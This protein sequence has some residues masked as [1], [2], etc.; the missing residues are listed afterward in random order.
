MKMKYFLKVLFAICLFACKER[1]DSPVDSPSHGYLVVEGIINTGK[2]GSSIT[3]SKIN[4]LKQA[5]IA[6]VKGATVQI[7]DE[8]NERYALPE[9]N[10]GVYSSDL[11]TLDTTRKYRVHIR[12]SEGK[13]YISDFGQGK[14]T[15]PID[16]V[17]WVREGGGLSILVNTH[18]I[19]NTTK[20]YR[21]EYEQTF[22]FHSGFAPKLKY[23]LIPLNPG[24]F[25]TVEYL[26]STKH[27]ADTSK[28]T[29]WQTSKSNSIIL[30]STA[31]LSVDKINMPIAAFPNGAKELSVLYTI[32]VKQFALTR[33]EYEYLDIMRKNTEITGSVFD[34]QPS[35]LKGNIHCIS[36]PDEPVIG[37]I[38]V[39]SLEEKR[40]FIKNS[41]LPD[42]KYNSACFEIPVDNISDSIV[43]P[44]ERGLVPTGPLEIAGN[45]VMVFNVTTKDCIDC[46]LS[47]TRSK[48]DFWP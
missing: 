38:G 35:Q 34:P 48:P 21:W 46:T 33:E 22:E 45:R 25:Y 47:G 44:Y 31:K 9:K 36:N 23:K 41:D 30:G 43:E 11:L 42:W 18:D 14:K 1:Y 2:G 19:R 6:Y 17:N 7:E 13:E 5:N 39:S 40:I 27:E 24:T 28:Y 37:Y 16:S 12:T 32:R 20:Y 26:D 3:L 8:A 10:N 15:P 4:S 29:C